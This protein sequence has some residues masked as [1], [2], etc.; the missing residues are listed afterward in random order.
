MPQSFR[1][2]HQVAAP[3]LLASA[4]VGIAAEVKQGKMPEL[5]KLENWTPQITNEETDFIPTDN[6][7]D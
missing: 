3:G 5:L 2:H 4:A 1:A 7:E 6:R